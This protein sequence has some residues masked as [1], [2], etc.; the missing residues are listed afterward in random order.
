MK[1]EYHTENLFTVKTIVDLCDK[2]E[3][4]NAIGVDHTVFF[5]YNNFLNTINK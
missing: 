3:F 1:N 4:V 2:R 5:D